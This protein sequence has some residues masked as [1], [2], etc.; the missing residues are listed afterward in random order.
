MGKLP[1]RDEAFLRQKLCTHAYPQLREMPFFGPNIKK[2]REYKPDTWRYR[3]G[4]FRAFYAIDDE[5][6][7]VFMLTVD[8]RKDAYR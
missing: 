4:R 8:R 6:K 5:E 7:I 1:E 3:I 2:L